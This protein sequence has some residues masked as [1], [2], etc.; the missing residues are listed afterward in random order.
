MSVSPSGCA[1]AYFGRDQVFGGA[2]L[3][4]EVGD[5]LARAG[6]ALLSAYGWCGPSCMLR[7]PSTD[8]GLDR[9]T[10]V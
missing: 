5:A 4:K 9:K 7:S 10:H 2:P 1:H 6:V 8:L 3:N